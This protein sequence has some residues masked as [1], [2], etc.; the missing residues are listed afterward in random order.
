MG[1]GP[2][3]PSGAIDF[4][5]KSRIHSVSLLLS[6]VVVTNGGMVHPAQGAADSI[7]LDGPVSFSVA[8]AFLTAKR[9][10]HQGFLAERGVTINQFHLAES[11]ETHVSAMFSL[12]LK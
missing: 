4:S 3:S 1:R 8:R 10:G 12:S 9:P 2:N 11:F 7:A 6:V 5:P